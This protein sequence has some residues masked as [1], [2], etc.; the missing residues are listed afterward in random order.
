LKVPVGDIVLVYQIYPKMMCG[1]ALQPDEELRQAF[2]AHGLVV[3]WED[4][5]PDDDDD[6]GES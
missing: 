6:E 3:T 4:Q 1:V 5:E 2:A